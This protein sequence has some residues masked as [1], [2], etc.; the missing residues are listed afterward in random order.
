MTPASVPGRESKAALLAF[1][2][3]TALTAVL[4][5][6]TTLRGK[7]AW[8]RLIRKPKLT[9]P[10]PVFGVVWTGLFALAA[11]SGWRVWRQE[12]SPQRTRALALWGTQL[13]LNANWT[14]LFFGR[15][16]ARAAFADLVALWATLGAYMMQTR[17]VD[18]TAANMMAPYLGWVTYAGYLNE[19]IVRRNRKL[20]VN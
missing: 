16:K 15:H 5:A 13:A 12:P 11:L 10:D 2:G 7:G 20:L 9:P 19:E 3:L 1:A 17:S 4:G 14:R 6:R 8:Y 18:R